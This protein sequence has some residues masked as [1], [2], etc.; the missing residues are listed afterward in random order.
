[1]NDSGIIELDGALARAVPARRLPA[2]D[3]A[4]L[5]GAF[6][7]ADTPARDL[8]AHVAG[9]YRLCD[10]DE[11]SLPAADPTPRRGHSDLR[12]A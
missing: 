11:R 1:M 6:A 9:R 12:A 2:A 3:N 4:A 5:F 8:A 10:Q 7:A